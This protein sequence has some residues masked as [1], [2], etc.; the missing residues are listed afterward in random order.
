MRH[1]RNLANVRRADKPGN[2]T[3]GRTHKL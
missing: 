3:I 1:P 2:M